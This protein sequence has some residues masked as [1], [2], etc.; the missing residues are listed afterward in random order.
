ASGNGRGDLLVRLFVEGRLRGTR[1]RSKTMCLPTRRMITI[2]LCSSV[3]AIFDAVDLRISGFSPSHTNSMTSPVT[4]LARPRAMVST[5]G[6]SGMCLPFDEGSSWRDSCRDWSG[7]E[8]SLF[9]QGDYG[10]SVAAEGGYFLQI[11]V[12]LRQGH[13]RAVAVH[14]MAGGGEVPASALGVLLDLPGEAAV[15]VGGWLSG[16]YSECRAQGRAQH[17]S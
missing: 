13:H 5:S 3:A 12:G 8:A 1:A 6:S 17:G 10:S 14:G 9:L 4:R 2:R 11:A 15:G 7:R 16:G